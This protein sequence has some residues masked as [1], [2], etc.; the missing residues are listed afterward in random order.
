MPLRLIQGL[1]LYF[2]LISILSAQNLDIGLINRTASADDG[3]TL[4]SPLQSTYTFL[5]D[6]DGRIVN[7]WKSDHVPGAS[8][9]LHTDGSMFRAGRLEAPAFIFGGGGA[10]GIIEQFDW[11]G[12]LLWQFVYSDRNVRQHHDIEILP[13]GNVLIAAWESIPINEVIAAGRNP[14]FLGNQ[15]LSEQLIEVKPNGPDGGEIV[16]RWRVWDHI[17]QDFDPNLQNFGDVSE[18]P[19][20][21]DINYGDAPRGDWVHIN[22]IDY[23]PEKD[24]ILLSSFGQ[25]EI[26]II[27]HSTTINEAAG[28]TGGRYGQGG[29][30]LF[31]WGNPLA[32]QNGS[33]D[34]RY[35]YDQHDAKWITDGSNKDGI[36]VFVNGNNRPDGDYSSVL[37]LNPIENNSQNYLMD[38]TGVYL[39][40][41]PFLEFTA[42]PNESFY[43]SFVSGADLLKNGNL[44]ICNGSVGTFFEVDETGQ[45]VWEYINPIGKDIL[46]TNPDS[47]ENQVFK[48]NR[49]SSDFEGFR[50][51]ILAP[52][53]DLT[54]TFG[55]DL[56]EVLI[57]PNPASDYLIV[58]GDFET[59][60]DVNF[61]NE[62]GYPAL[63][64][65]AL[66][67]E[68]VIALSFNQVP[69]GVYFLKI[70]K[71][72][73]YRVIVNR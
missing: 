31:R 58:E 70:G 43:S 21:I 19:G 66:Y 22:S 49:Y 57:Y 54:E 15:F 65:L 51:K 11:N 27:D 64:D 3:L 29:N 61:Y 5:I 45:S 50:G 63:A 38:E 23:H 14:T 62:A 44:L 32:H 12:E 55:Q 25:N 46:I 56:D 18:N 4:F 20:L 13:N 42:D 16:W 52:R 36:I 6:V 35:F 30:L 71:K 24:Q 10:G 69:N 53:R 39:P 37:A 2:S 67:S 8:S 28:S 1:I 48:I 72:D 41:L 26:W 7:E 73:A 40:E 34:L 17:I 59:L 9:Y 60:A 68:K 47:G 33:P